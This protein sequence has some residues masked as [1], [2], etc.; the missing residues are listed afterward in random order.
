MN[1]NQLR[2]IRLQRECTTTAMPAL[3][4]AAA[5]AA[6]ALWAALQS[7]PAAP[8]AEQSAEPIAQ[9]AAPAA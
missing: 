4:L 6:L 2:L 9:D 8:T 7:A 1:M 5:C 3:L